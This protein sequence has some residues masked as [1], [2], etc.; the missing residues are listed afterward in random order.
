MDQK[1]LVNLREIKDAQSNHKKDISAQLLA[2]ERKLKN[3]Q[4]NNV[5][6]D[7]HISFG[8]ESSNKAEE[9]FNELE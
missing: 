8:D 7:A 9:R 5:K 3:I 2:F 6:D 1:N 4:N